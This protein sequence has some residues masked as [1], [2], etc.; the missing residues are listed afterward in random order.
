MKNENLTLM[1]FNILC[2]KPSDER[3]ERLIA[4]T[5]KYSA[6][7][8]GMQEVTPYWLSFLKPALSD[9]ECVGLGRD[10]EDKGEHSCIFYNKNKLKLV[11]TK[12][13]WLT[14]TPDQVSVIPGSDYIR[15]V[16]FALL[17]RKSDGK[18]FVHANTHID[19]KEAAYVTQ[20]KYLLK[21]AK[22][23]A[24]YPMIVTGDFNC[25]PTTEGYATMIQ[26]GFAD[27]SL[28]AEQAV[29]EKT[30]HSMDGSPAVATIDFAFVTPEKIKVHSYK[31]CSEQILGG[32]AS[33]HH[34]V[35][36]EYS[37]K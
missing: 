13:L 12:T 28:V 18:R 35:L 32:Y 21:F 9:Y 23:Y 2:D 24:E 8:I 11:E 14:D 5:K 7:S 10:G 33:D 15:I 31:V 20:I 27:S 29:C 6:D 30:L 34:P 36:I 37:F 4:M 25:D 22:E 19:Y 3:I 1:S 16:T 17:E 26:N